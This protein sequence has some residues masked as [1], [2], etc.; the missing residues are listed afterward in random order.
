MATGLAFFG[1][2]GYRANAILD[3][4]TDNEL[5]VIQRFIT[6]MADSVRQQAQDLER[7]HARAARPPAETWHAKLNA[8]LAS[9]TPSAP[10]RLIYSIQVR[11]YRGGFGLAGEFCAS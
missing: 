6:A 1:S 9:L 2:L 3:Q 7:K 11:F 10:Y 8:S 5:L 4:F